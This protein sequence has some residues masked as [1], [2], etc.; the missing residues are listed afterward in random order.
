M[1]KINKII[2]FVKKYKTYIL[3]I[4]IIILSI[5]S[6]I[7]Q[8][9][10]KNNKINVNSITSEEKEEKIAVYINGAVK[11]PGVYYLETNARLYELLDICGGIT[12][13]ADINNINLAKKLVD[14]DMITI[15]EKQDEIEN[16]DYELEESSDKVNINTASKS[17]LMSLN[18]IGEQT[19]NN[20][21]N[22]RETIKFNDIE[23]LMN[24]N[25]IG[26]SKYE[27]IKDDICVN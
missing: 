21:I 1:S 5:I 4:T 18:G 6:V 15:T 16:I 11:N 17:E 9:I 12:E 7:I 25:G 27:N 13:N 3:C 2:K 19:A 26:I 22:Y 20:I 8:Y 23:D 10:D 24:V 14:S